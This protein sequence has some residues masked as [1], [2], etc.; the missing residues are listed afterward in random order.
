MKRRGKRSDKETFH[1]NPS[2]QHAIFPMPA[3]HFLELVLA[4]GVGRRRYG[5]MVGEKVSGLAI[6]TRE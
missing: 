4:V 5:K 1:S 6:K 3:V 2:H